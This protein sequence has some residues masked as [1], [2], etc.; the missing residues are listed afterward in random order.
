M[1]LDPLPILAL[2]ERQSGQGGNA[3]AAAAA[4]AA[5]AAAAAAVPQGNR[6]TPVKRAKWHLGIRSQSKPN[7]IMNEVYRAMKAL[8]FVSILYFLR[9]KK[10]NVKKYFS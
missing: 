3:A 2:R 5:A 10:Y 6:G 9:K 8:D 4:V 7:D 1:T